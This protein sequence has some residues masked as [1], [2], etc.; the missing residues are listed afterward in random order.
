MILDA[1]LDLGIK[2]D[3][4]KERL[5][6]R[7]TNRSTFPLTRFR[8]FASIHTRRNHKRASAKTIDLHQKDPITIAGGGILRRNELDYLCCVAERLGTASGIVGA[9]SCLSKTL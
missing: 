3:T 7:I 2:N 4:V 5:Y 9:K 1:D 6:G 8:T